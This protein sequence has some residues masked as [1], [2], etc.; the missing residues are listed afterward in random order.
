MLQCNKFARDFL[1]EKV[2]RQFSSGPARR[3]QKTG[4]RT[5][6][7]RQLYAERQALGPLVDGY[8]QTRN[9]QEGP[10]PVELCAAGM[11]KPFWCFAG[12]R[13]RNDDFIRVDDV[14]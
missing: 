14:V 4:L 6:Q 13:E 5:A 10:K 11:A 7:R 8:M 9:M 12:R 1:S 3:R 2:E